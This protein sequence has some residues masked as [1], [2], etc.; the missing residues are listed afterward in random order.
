MIV[1]AS[2]LSEIRREADR[3]RK[4]ISEFGLRIV[5]RLKKLCIRSGATEKKYQVKANESHG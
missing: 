5:Y 1:I 3:N 2:E 4:G